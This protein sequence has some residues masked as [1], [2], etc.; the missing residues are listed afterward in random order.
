MIQRS[1][2]LDDSISGLRTCAVMLF[3][4]QFILD[5]DMAVDNS[6][7]APLVLTTTMDSIKYSHISV[8]KELSRLLVPAPPVANIPIIA[9]KIHSQEDFIP[10][11]VARDPVG[12]KSI[13]TLMRDI[14]NK[15]CL[16][17]STQSLI[18]D[19]RGMELLVRSTIIELHLP[20]VD[21]YRQIWVPAEGETSMVVIFRLQGLDGEATEP[22]N[23]AFPSASEGDETPKSR[24]AYT[25]VSARD[26]GFKPLLKALRSDQ[27]IAF[28]PDA[29]KCLNAFAAIRENRAAL[30]RD[31]DIQLGFDV[32]NALIAQDV[33]PHLFESVV[34]FIG[35]LASEF[36]AMDTIPEK[37]IDFIFRTLSHPIVRHNESLLLPILALVPPLA[38]GSPVLMEK[39]LKSFLSELW[40]SD[41]PESFNIFEKPTSVR[42]LNGFGDFALALPVDESGNTIRDVILRSPFVTD[43]VSFLTQLLPYTE[44]EDPSWPDEALDCPASPAVLKTFNG[45]VSS[46]QPT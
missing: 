38:S 1:K 40:P 27:S 25:S 28:V 3:S 26:H 41:G 36:C 44:G 15:I 30:A 39:V 46:H 16:D 12:S 9:R 29:A 37:H 7:S 8:V 34:R 14:Q 17:L 21:I 11:R 20:I 24:S 4:K 6:I 10:G 43:A 22:I 32:R 31:S 45:M 13:G 5:A 42:V 19:H 35:S 23:R 33:K 2:Y 18:E